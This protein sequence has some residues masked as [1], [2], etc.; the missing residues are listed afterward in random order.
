MRALNAKTGEIVWSFRTGSNFRSS[1]ISYQGPD[2]RQY[3]AI[4]ASQLGA[5]TQ[6]KADMPADA[7]ARFRRS[8]ATLYVFALPKPP[9]ARR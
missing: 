9:A 4:I 2:G 1:P 3:I 6:V 7:D 5:N 8:G